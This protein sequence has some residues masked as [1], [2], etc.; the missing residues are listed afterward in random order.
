MPLFASGPCVAPVWPLCG[1]CVAPVWPLSGPCQTHGFLVKD[2]A[3]AF[4]QSD[5]LGI[6]LIC[7]PLASL[8]QLHVSVVSAM[9]YEQQ[10]ARQDVKRRRLTSKTCVATGLTDG[11]RTATCEPRRK[12]SAPHF[13]D[14]CCKLLF[15][16]VLCSCNTAS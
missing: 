8:A 7:F 13:K 16:A 5:S 3:S 11:I 2:L 10:H 4:S 15:H 14:P 1:P 9:E 6:W 12:A